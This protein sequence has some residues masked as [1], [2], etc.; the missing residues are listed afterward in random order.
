M[1]RGCFG[2]FVLKSSLRAFLDSIHVHLCHPKQQTTE[3]SF[4]M[5]QFSLKKQRWTIINFLE[6]S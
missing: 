2:S 5:L 4:K 1:S 6:F 3:N